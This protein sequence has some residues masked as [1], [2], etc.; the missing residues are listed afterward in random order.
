MEIEVLKIDETPDSTLSQM[1]IDGKFFCFVL[2]DGYRD[3]KE[4]GQSRIPHGS[5]NLVRRTVGGFYEDFKRRFGHAFSIEL[6]NIPGFRFILIHTGNT[7]RDTAGCLL[8]GDTAGFDGFNFI[9]KGS[10][11]AYKS[12][13]AI[14]QKSFDRGEN[15]VCHVLRFAVSADQQT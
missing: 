12:F 13:Y 6:E 2:E 7:V 3:K 14:V 11:T 15:V 9:L 8:V 5:Y 1:R 10:A 4:P